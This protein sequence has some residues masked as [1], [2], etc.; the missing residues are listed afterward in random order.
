MRPAVPL[1]RFEAF[2]HRLDHAERLAFD[3]GDLSA[4]PLAFPNGMS[5]RAC[6]RW[7]YKAQSTR[8]NVLRLELKPEG[9][10]GHPEMFARVLA[11]VPDG[12]A[13]DAVGNLYVT[14]CASDNVD[15]VSPRG[16]VA[17]RYDRSGTVIATPTNAAFLPGSGSIDPA[18]VGRWHIWRVHIGVEARPLFLGL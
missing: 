5:L 4:G 2:A 6:E 12:V 17:V 7:L 8:D 10:C 13:L 16:R 3:R 18:N 11:R 1:A 14:C 15:R 9:R